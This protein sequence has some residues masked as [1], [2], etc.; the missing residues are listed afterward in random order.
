M[1]AAPVSRPS[2]P[3]NL[4]VEAKPCLVVGAGPVAARKVDGLRLSGANITVVAPEAVAEIRGAKDVRW[5]QRAYRRGEVA[6]YRLAIS[7]TGIV[8]V[9][10]QVHRDAEAAGV[11]INSADDPERCSFTLPAVVRQRDLQLAISTGGRSPA[12]ARWLR[13]RFE[14]EIGPEYAELLDL[15]AETRHEVRT[16]QGT[17][18]V[19]GWDEALDNGVLDLI[20]AGDPVGARLKL[21]D[22]LDL[23]ATMKASA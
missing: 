21:R 1:W 23:P 18:E 6:S 4:V 3:V 16:T 9:D 7:A 11:W 13:S 14:R 15:L 20:I 5:H 10:A 19:A 17:S 2:Y 12:L 22:A 8:D